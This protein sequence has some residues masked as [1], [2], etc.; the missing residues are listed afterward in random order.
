M[1]DIYG[2]TKSLKRSSLSRHYKKF[3]EKFW[4]YLF[5]YPSF[6]PPLTIALLSLWFPPII[7][8]SE[9]PIRQKLFQSP[10]LFHNKLAIYFK[11]SGNYWPMF[12]GFFVLTC[13]VLALYI[14]CFDTAVLETIPQEHQ[15]VVS[16][17]GSH[18]LFCGCLACL[19]LLLGLLPL[20]SAAS[21]PT[22]PA[23]ARA[24]S[25][26]EPHFLSRAPMTHEGA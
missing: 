8:Y 21:P 1:V 20:L 23:G 11:M 26:G 10:R 2:M 6:Y 25:P 15:V 19:L 3:I 5:T 9:I 16:Q 13:V 12:G 4:I 17:Y 22:L 7:W 18:S 24:E 14:V